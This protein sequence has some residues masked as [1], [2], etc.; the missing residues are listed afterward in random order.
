M[1]DTMVLLSLSRP[2]TLSESRRLDACKM[3]P[4]RVDL[5][6]VPEICQPDR[7]LHMCFLMQHM[8]VEGV[9]EMTV[10]QRPSMSRKG[11]VSPVFAP[12][13]KYGRDSTQKLRWEIS[14]ACR[15]A[16]Q[17]RP[18][19]FPRVHVHASFI[20][21]KTSVA[22]KLGKERSSWPT[23]LIRRIRCNSREKC[24]KLDHLECLAVGRISRG[25]IHLY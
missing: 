9:G 18:T 25:F 22:Q 14:P 10:L 3:Q 21:N 6:S 16:D 15:P 24:K 2:P 13:T 19:L 17:T 4:L 12:C 23:D 8:P 20:G 11:V 1:E 7:H 5:I